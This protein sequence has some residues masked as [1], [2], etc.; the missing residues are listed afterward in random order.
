MLKFLVPLYVS[1]LLEPTSLTKASESVKAIHDHLLSQVT[2]VGPKHPDI[3]RS[4]M[5]ATPSLNQRLK[6][7]LQASHSTG[8]RAVG[9]GRRNQQQAPAIKLKMDFSNFK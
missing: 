4:I 5:V 8:A 6:A 1:L 2:Q 7:A 3:F 9:E